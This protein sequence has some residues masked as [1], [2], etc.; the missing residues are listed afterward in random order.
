MLNKLNSLSTKAYIKGCAAIQNMKNGAKSFLSDERGLSGVVVAVLL[1]LVAVLAVTLLWG[2]LS[3]WI[4]T[5]WG[6]ITTD[7]MSIS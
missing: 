3:A 5:L 4:S 1:I 2:Q 7:S 6:K